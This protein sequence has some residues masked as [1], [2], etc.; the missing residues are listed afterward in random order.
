MESMDTPPLWT[1]ELTLLVLFGPN[2]AGVLNN[3]LAEEEE[4]GEHGGE[5]CG[6]GWG[7]GS[8][9]L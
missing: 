9:R 5:D 3:G 2:G 4:E 7:E 1:L 8:G 6:E